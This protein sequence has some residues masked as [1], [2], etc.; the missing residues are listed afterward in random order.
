MTDIRALISTFAARSRYIERMR[1][2]NDLLQDEY[3][4][5][6]REMLKIRA[7]QTAERYFHRITFFP[8]Y[9]RIVRSFAGS[10]YSAG[11]EHRVNG[12]PADP[13]IAQMLYGDVTHADRARRR[14]IRFM[15]RVS[16]SL[17]AHRTTFVLF[18]PAINRVTQRPERVT[19]RLIEPH[20]CVVVGSDGEFDGFSR[21]ADA[22]AV[23][24]KLSSHSSDLVSN[25]AA[26]KVWT[27][28]HIVTTTAQGAVLSE[29]PNPLSGTGYPFPLIRLFADP[30]PEGAYA[31]EG[32]EAL[33]NASL[34]AAY[35]ETELSVAV[36]M[37]DQTAVLSGYSPEQ[38][39]TIT[40][41]PF[42]PLITTEAQTQVLQ[43]VG[44]QP[45]AAAER[46]AQLMA[47]Y[48]RLER[49]YNQIP[50]SL[51]AQSDSAISGVARR[52]AQ[53]PLIAERN[54]WISDVIAG[55][56]AA[57]IAAMAFHYTL[58]VQG[59]LPDPFV[60]DV[61]PEAE[62]LYLDPTEQRAE[63]RADIEAALLSPVDVIAADEG[64]SREE[65]VIKHGANIAE[66]NAGKRD[67]TADQ[68]EAI[69]L[70]LV[71]PVEV[72]AQRMG[73][74]RAAASVVYRQNIAD[75]DSAT[76]E[77]GLFDGLG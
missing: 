17:W 24:L 4:V 30:I 8:I 50:G 14:W 13:W 56:D 55:C 35:G 34:Q 36:E 10:P 73:I 75:R 21:L 7:P 67:P 41:S 31:P 29:E 5:Y 62:T 6:I 63:Q 52:I 26:F 46:R 39:T 32:G 70:G 18:E 53:R 20:T 23:V 60:P 22:A 3:A 37:L 61:L 68:R 9:R 1:R 64:I 71:S 49:S 45:G 76:T 58:W 25:S 66:R 19:V 16:V 47:F 69:E 28:E 77:R 57:I 15:D 43:Y 59:R 72:I 27:R 33:V 38:G 11:V 74:D 44:P 2:R 42:A 51:S 48:E 65:A 40:L 54:A 12:E